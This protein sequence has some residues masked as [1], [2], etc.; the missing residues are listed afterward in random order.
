MPFALDYLSIY[1]VGTGFIQLT[2]GMNDNITTQGFARTAMITTMTG[3]LCNV[4][5]DPLFIFVFKM[6]VRGAALATVLAQ[7]ISFLWVMRFLFGRQTRLHLS[8]R[9]IRLQPGLLKEIVGLGASPFFMSLSEGVLVVCFNT[10]A[11]KLGGDVA[12]SAIAILFSLFQFLL[13]PVEGV[14]QGAQPIL[15]YNYGARQYDRVME[16]IRLGSPMLQIYIG[17]CFVLGANSTFQ[18]TYNALGEG[19]CSFFFAFYRK[20]IL[21]IPLI[22]ILPAMTGLGIFGLVLAEPVSD[23]LTTFTNALYFRIFIHKKL[24]EQN[25]SEFTSQKE[26]KI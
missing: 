18:Q 14:S 2:V 26:A 10:Q 6:G 13:L 15:S 1:I 25:V 12:V 24:E 9:T 3:A 20:A 17:G 21:L 11:L 8:F 5:L 19:K 7:M 16:T 23:L 4:V 22:Y